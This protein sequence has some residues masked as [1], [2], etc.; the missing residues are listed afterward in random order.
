MNNTDIDPVLNNCVNA[1]HFKDV[2]LITNDLLS[3]SIFVNNMLIKKEPVSLEFL[4]KSKACFQG[5]LR[6]RTTDY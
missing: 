3:Q 6:R 4:F 1:R 5:R 2:A